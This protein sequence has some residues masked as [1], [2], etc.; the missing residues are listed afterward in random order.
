MLICTLFVCV[1]KSALPGSTPFASIEISREWTATLYLYRS[2]LCWATVATS[3]ILAVRR[4]AR[5]GYVFSYAVLFEQCTLTLCQTWRLPLS[6]D[7]WRGLR[8]EGVSQEGWSQTMVEPSRVLPR[9]CGPHLSSVKSNSTWSTIEFSGHS[10]WRRPHGG[11]GSS[12]T[13]WS[14]KRCWHKLISQSCDELSTMLIEI[15]E[16][17]DELL[18]SSH[19]LCAQQVLTSHRISQWMKNSPWHTPTWPDVWS[20]W[21]PLWKHWRREYLLEIR[22]AHRWNPNAAYLSAG[23]SAGCQPWGLWKLSSLITGQ[24]GH[25]RGAVLQIPSSGSN[26]I[27]QHPLQHLYP[28]E[29]A[30]HSVQHELLV[31]HRQKRWSLGRPN[32]E[33]WGHDEQQCLRPG[34]ASSV[35]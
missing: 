31:H 27:L 1:T 26:G 33:L 8:P 5:C 16:D 2:G 29:L 10:I 15:A 9:R 20:F 18:T 23:D 19:F 25:P 3:S 21:M 34:Q 35:V 6:F 17:L 32:L 30:S 7:A 12:N 4:P 14:T 28:L 11:A 13:W 22:E 24:D